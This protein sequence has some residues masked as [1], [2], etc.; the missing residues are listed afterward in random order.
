MRKRQQDEDLEIVRSAAERRLR[1]RRLARDPALSAARFRAACLRMMASQ[2]LSRV[3]EGLCVRISFAN[4]VAPAGD[5][6]NV[7]WDFEV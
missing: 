5:V 3:L 7:A 1:L 2:G 6:I 4:Q